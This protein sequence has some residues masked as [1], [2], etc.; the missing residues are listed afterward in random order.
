VCSRNSW[1]GKP[2]TH[3]GEHGRREARVGGFVLP[4]NW[5]FCGLLSGCQGPP[6]LV[7]CL[8]TSDLTG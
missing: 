6:I 3:P 1:R 4:G 7:H 8:T 5:V 2:R